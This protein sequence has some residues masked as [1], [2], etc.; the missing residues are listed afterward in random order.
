MGRMNQTRDLSHT[1]FTPP[2][3]ETGQLTYVI[4][5]LAIGIRSI[6]QR[7]DH[8]WRH[9]QRHMC[10]KWNA[11]QRATTCIYSWK[12][13]TTKT[14]KARCDRLLLTNSA[15][16]II[17]R[18]TVGLTVFFMWRPLLGDRGRITKHSVCHSVI[19]IFVFVR[20]TYFGEVFCALPPR[21]LRPGYFTLL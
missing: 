3:H 4:S 16:F 18:L 19:L 9:M 13:L 7:G 14:P 10:L 11:M 21:L 2:T 6:E 5:A 8:M 20:Q 17:V 1:V 15:N 12:K